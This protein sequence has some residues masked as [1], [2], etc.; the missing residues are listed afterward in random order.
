VR[1]VSL[2]ASATEMVC[3][4]GAG[5]WLV[6]RSHECD[7]PPLVRALPACSEP[8]FDVAVSSGAIDAEVRRRIRAREPLYIIHTERIRQLR[9]DLVITQSHCD[10]CAVTPENVHGIEAAQLALAAGSVEGIFDDIVRVAQALGLAERGR[11]LV[12]AERRRLDAVRARTAALPRPGV[13]LLEWTDPL[14]AMGNW[15]PELV[16]IAGG[17]LR[18]G[19]KGEYSAAI[20]AEQL[21]AADPECIVV[22]PCGFNLA[23][24]LAEKAVLE[25]LP[26]WRE[27]RAVRNGRVAFADGN[28]Y[29]NRSGMT[30]SRTAEILADILHGG[31]AEAGV[32]Q[33]MP[34]C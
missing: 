32:W 24:A 23:R 20:D 3:A 1:I 30:V 17:D 12:E 25:Q 18:I 33:W 15:G 4:L 34:Q 29:F 19:R 13:V 16:E 21:R 7:N 5:D 9:P 26:W 2:L 28:L 27:L 8:A 10:V 14:F 6:G 31:S 22:A 11:E